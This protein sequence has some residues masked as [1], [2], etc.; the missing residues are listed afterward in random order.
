MYMECCSY[1]TIHCVVRLGSPAPPPMSLLCGPHHEGGDDRCPVAE[2]NSPRGISQRLASIAR[3]YTKG[4]PRTV[5]RLGASA[6]ASAGDGASGGGSDKHKAG[7][8]CDGDGERLMATTGTA[9]EHLSP[10]WVQRRDPLTQR[11]VYVHTISGNTSLTAPSQLTRNGAVCTG[12]VLGP[13]PILPR[14]GSAVAEGPALPGPRGSSCSPAVIAAAPHLTH[15]FTPFLPRDR[16]TRH[17][18]PAPPPGGAPAPPSGGTPAPPP[19]GAPAPP[20]G[21]EPAPPPGVALASPPGVEPGS[22][23]WLS[24][25]KWRCGHHQDLDEVPSLSTVPLLLQNWENPAFG[26]SKERV[27]YLA[28]HRCRCTADCFASQ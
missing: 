11:M 20:P 2:T 27:R 24:Q 6:G 15:S 26:P 21:G 23:Q 12:I 14:N 19:G 9:G 4:V 8:T 10:V 7:Y 16:L 28:C 17:V 13:R 5:T 25:S 22:L 3:E 1:K 18:Q